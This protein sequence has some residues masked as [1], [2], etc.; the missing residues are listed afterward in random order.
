MSV[1]LFR[2][3]QWFGRTL[4]TPLV[5]NGSASRSL[6]AAQALSGGTAV[7]VIAGLVLSAFDPKA[8]PILIATGFAGGL[9]VSVVLYALAAVAGDA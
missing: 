6:R 5:G 7:G 2:F 3:A 4:L 1:V 8:A 9:L